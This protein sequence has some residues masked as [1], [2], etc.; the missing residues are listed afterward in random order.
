MTRTRRYVHGEALTAGIDTTGELLTQE[1][2]DRD[3][4]TVSIEAD[5]ASDFALDIKFDQ[6]GSF[7]EGWQTYSGS[8]VQ[9]TL[10][11]T[12]YEVRIRNTTA[13]T[14]GDTA[15]VRVGAE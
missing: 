1:T 4:V 13:Q 3:T 5:V 15:D 7:V 11:L 2:V 12:V 14:G 8:S 9:D 10:D 6:D